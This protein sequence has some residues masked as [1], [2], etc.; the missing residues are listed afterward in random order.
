MAAG[1]QGHGRKRGYHELEGA[2]SKGATMCTGSCDAASLGT[3]Q[4]LCQCF[5][6]E[7]PKQIKGRFVANDLSH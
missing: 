2:G 5:E 4:L 1:V 6:P 7:L 3:F